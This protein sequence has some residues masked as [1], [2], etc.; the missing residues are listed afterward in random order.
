MGK[1]PTDR[2]KN[3]TKR[4]LLVEEQGGPLGIV[5]AA[6]NVN[7]HRLLR[8]T[9]ERVVGRSVAVVD[10]AFTTAI[11]VEDLLDALRA[12]S[13]LTGSGAADNRIATTGDVAAFTAVA[14]RV[15]GDRLPDVESV[16][17]EAAVSSKA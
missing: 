5:I 1:N 11:A 8:A 10:S 12:R 7:D 17:V 16:S 14:A 9:I 6:A 2:G 4:S 13:D 15:F 3:G